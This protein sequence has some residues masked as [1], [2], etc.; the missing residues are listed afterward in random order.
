MQD[1]QTKNPIVI[2][3][4]RRRMIQAG[5][6]AVATLGFTYINT[7]FAQ[8]GRKIKIG[9][10]APESGPLAPFGEAD[11]FVIGTIRELMKG[12]LAIGG[13]NFPVEIIV[14]DSQSNPNRAG[15]VA[16]DLILKDKVD[17][18]LAGGT[19]ETT[20]PVAD[21]SELNEVPC[22]T[23]VTRSRLQLDLSFLLGLGRHHRRVHQFVGSGADQQTSRRIV[24]ERR[25]RQCLG[26]SQC[27]LPKTARRAGL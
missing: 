20:N 12:G 21:Q 5:A 2:E 13:K 17:I 26:R 9:Y 1:K 3:Y 16:A 7:A 23:S 24:P 22:V 11:K 8:A 4:S 27:G 14:K 19:P 25:R 6:A 10:V 15:E 18:M